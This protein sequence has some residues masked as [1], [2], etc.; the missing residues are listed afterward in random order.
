MLWRFDWENHPTQQM[1]W[2][3]HKVEMLLII[4]EMLGL[5][6]TSHGEN[7]LKLSKLY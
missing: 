7:D 2:L 1:I 5:I 3:K 6:C 4:T